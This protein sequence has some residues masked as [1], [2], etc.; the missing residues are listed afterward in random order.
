MF[1]N[2]FSSTLPAVSGNEIS[3]L[4]RVGDD[5]ILP[6]LNAMEGQNH[7][8]GLTW[9]FASRNKPERVRLSESDRVSVTESCSVLIQKLTAEDVGH[10]Y[11]R[12]ETKVQQFDLRVITSEYLPPTIYH[13]A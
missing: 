7:C 11:C 6:F 13:S 12:H 9:T 4:K 10:Y 2:H 5:V 3:I 1:R 8:D